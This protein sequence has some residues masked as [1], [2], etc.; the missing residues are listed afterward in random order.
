MGKLVDRLPEPLNDRIIRLYHRGREFVQ[1]GDLTP[2]LNLSPEAFNKY[3]QDVIIRLIEQEEESL[4]DKELIDAGFAKESPKSS[5]QK[6][7]AEINDK[8]KNKDR[9]KDTSKKTTETLYRFG[10]Y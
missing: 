4:N 2:I 8:F 6:K 5:R 7:T 1:I 3:V 9:A 10:K